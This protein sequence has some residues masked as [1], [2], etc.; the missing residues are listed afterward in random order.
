MTT[1][2]GVIKAIYVIMLC[3]VVSLLS[4]CWMP[5]FMFNRIVYFFFVGFGVGFF[6]AP[7][8]AVIICAVKEGLFK[9]VS[10]DACNPCHRRRC[11]D[12][13]SRIPWRP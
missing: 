3:V 6:I 2:G 10:G 12:R 9:Y 5:R 11:D 1:A 13:D 8:I 4:F 7:S